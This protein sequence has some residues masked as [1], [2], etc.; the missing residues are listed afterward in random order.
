MHR[1]VVLSMTL[2]TAPPL[3]ATSSAPQELVSF[4]T[5]DGGV[6]YAHLY[7]DGD[8]GVILVHGGRFDKS[9]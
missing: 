2:V 3:L 4:R 6:V 1:L 7:G 5:E 9:S 8:H